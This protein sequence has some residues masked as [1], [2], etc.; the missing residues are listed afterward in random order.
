MQAVLQ[1]G[2]HVKKVDALR[3]VRVLVESWN[4]EVVGEIRLSGIES[5]YQDYLD[6]SDACRDVMTVAAQNLLVLLKSY[7]I[8]EECSK[9]RS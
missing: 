6:T 4:A 5:S 2:T 3:A 8:L 9:W 7:F 1:R